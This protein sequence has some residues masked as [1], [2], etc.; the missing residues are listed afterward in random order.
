MKKI[1]LQA[2]RGVSSEAPENTLAAFQMAVDQGYDIIELDPKYTKDNVCVILHDQKLNRTCRFP[3]GEELPE[4]AISELTLAEARSYDAGI[5]MG[6]RF[7]G[8]K[9]PT[10]REVFAWIGKKPICCKLDN[11]WETFSPLQKEDFLNRIKEADLGGKIGVTCRV[12]EC[13]ELAAREI[14]DCELHWDGALDEETLTKVKKAC[15]SH[16]VTIWVRL[17][18]KLTSW[19]KFP[20]ATPELCHRIRRYGEIG[21]WL[22]SQEEEFQKAVTDLK[23]DTVETTGH[24]KPRGF[25][26]EER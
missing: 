20:P 13:L 11:V 12:L 16:R 25:H 17:D 3:D 5:F 2:H 24:I 1:R 18:N 6:E 22:L 21:V 14:P 9:I 7:R 19:C 8:E 4:L 23:A 15:G 10:L 26:R